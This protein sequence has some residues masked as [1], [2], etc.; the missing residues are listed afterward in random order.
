MEPNPTICK[1]ISLLK[2]IS[3]YDLLAKSHIRMMNTSSD[4]FSYNH[5]E[6]WRTSGCTPI[7]VVTTVRLSIKCYDCFSRST[8]LKYEDIEAALIFPCELHASHVNKT[9]QDRLCT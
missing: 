9:K 4:Q 5:V 7:N 2:S 1:F 8:L 6:C 3:H